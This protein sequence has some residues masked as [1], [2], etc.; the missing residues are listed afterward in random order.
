MQR[1][2][3]SCLLFSL[4][5]V[6]VSGRLIENSA[7]DLVVIKISKI[8]FSIREFDYMSAS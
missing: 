1:I 6:Q 5:E 2:G 4:S 8:S 3:F 7:L